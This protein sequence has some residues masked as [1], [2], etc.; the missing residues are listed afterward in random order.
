MI[1]AA[2]PAEGRP[3]GRAPVSAEFV[4]AMACRFRPLSW[5]ITGE[6]PAAS[7]RRTRWAI[8]NGLLGGCTLRFACLHAS[9]DF[10]DQPRSVKRLG[11]ETA[12]ARIQALVAVA[13]HRVGRQGYDR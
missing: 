1:A 10:C 2:A 7:R 9:T 12:A 4:M 11:G 8:E 6:K 3:M 5:P 13:T